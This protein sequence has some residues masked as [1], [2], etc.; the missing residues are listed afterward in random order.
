MIDDVRLPEYIEQGSEGGPQFYT[1]VLKLAS[2]KEARNQNWQYA[3][4]QYTIS[5]GTDSDTFADIVR[6]FRA[7]RGRLRGFRFKDWSDFQCLNGYIGTGDGTRTV[8]NL[9]KVYID[10]VASYGR[11]ITRPVA[12]TLHVYFDTVET[13]AYTYNAGVLTFTAP[14]TAGVVITASFDFDVPV[15]FDSDTLQLTVYQPNASEVQSIGLTEI[16]E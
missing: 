4:C 9:V 10:D 14:V 13:V 8:W 5:Y 12:G 7:R 15:R 16:I 3:K 2:G 6:F 11:P 1:S